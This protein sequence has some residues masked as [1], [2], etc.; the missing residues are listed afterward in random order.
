[1]QDEIQILQGYPVKVQSLD[2][3]TGPIRTILNQVPE[4]QQVLHWKKA[5]IPFGT[6]LQIVAFMKWSY[7]DTKAEAQLRLFYNEETDEWKPVVYPQ[8]KGTGLYTEEAK[9][10]E[11][12]DVALA[13]VPVS[14]GWTEAGTVHHH[15]TISAFQSATDLKDEIEKNGLHITLGYMNKTD[16]YDFHARAT[17][18][19]ICYDVEISEWIDDMGGGLPALT[20]AITNP[21]ELFPEEWQERLIEKP[22]AP[23]RS[24]GTSTGKYKNRYL[25]DSNDY[26]GYGYSYGYGYGYNYNTSNV[27][28]S[29]K[30]EDKDNEEVDAVLG[31]IATLE[32]TMGLDI[33]SALA[34]Q[35]NWE[36]FMDALDQVIDV[37]D[38]IR[39]S[40]STNDALDG[41]TL[42]HM[43]T[44]C[45]QEG[46]KIPRSLKFSF[47]RLHDEVQ[48]ALVEE[49]A[50]EEVEENGS[51]ILSDHSKNTQEELD[52][53]VIDDVV[54]AQDEINDGW[55]DEDWS[56]FEMF[57]D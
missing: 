20:Q 17:F 2:H 39:Y 47:W 16:F 40:E 54:E 3:Y 26:Y 36:D 42:L 41:E 18:R 35:T 29:D 51:V 11:L 53:R 5:K 23:V 10:H 22:K 52:F 37:L 6:W 1:M 9:E 38:T 48:A 45:Y 14:E 15:C 12:R 31:I 55:V 24:S 43:A 27:A 57:D 21:T 4:D 7:D 49:L 56:M 19:K 25:Y 8:Y 33:N 30:S 13:E 44:V 28:S 32:Q 50:D 34:S 46:I